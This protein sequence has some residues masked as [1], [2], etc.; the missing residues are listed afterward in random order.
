[1]K[2]SKLIKESS[3]YVNSYLF[4]FMVT[5][6]LSVLLCSFGNIKGTQA[7]F[8][9]VTGVIGS[10]YK[11]IYSSNWPDVSFG[12]DQ[13]VVSNLSSSSYLI[14]NNLFN[15]PD[16]YEFIDWNTLSDG[17]GISYKPDDFVNIESVL[18]LYAQ[19]NIIVDDDEN[20]DSVEG[21]ITTGDKDD[22]SNS[23]SD[24]D[25]MS[26]S[27]D[28]SSN[29]EGDE[30]DMS[31]SL[32]DSDKDNSTGSSD[33]NEENSGSI[34][35]N[36][37]GSGT[38]G[39]GTGSSGSSGGQ[40]SANNAGV[41]GGSSSSGNVS[42]SDNSN[43]SSNESVQQ[44]NSIDEE[45]FVVY[46][47]K[48]MNGNNEFAST[49]CEILKDNY[50]ELL[51]PKDNPIKDGYT[52]KGWSLSNLCSANDIIIEPVK[53]NSDNTYYACFEINVDTKNEDNGWIY[54]VI[55]VWV[56]ASVAIYFAIRKFKKNNRLEENG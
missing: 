39:S 43:T 11:V 5:I 54:L 18:Y 48:F 15:V 53:V 6:L 56:I 47:F 30:D 36:G 1:M 16:G 29:S 2:Y 38:T 42:S 22:S 3:R 24:E 19:W 41:A 20:N 37:T 12:A 31:G 40:N 14:R 26:G 7:S 33:N 32:D 23:E 13:T 45:I 35:N 10:S 25:D 21:D 4:S 34:S 28:D 17:S 46:K 50:C 51:L 27:L 52:F 55:S 44:E 9:G 49:S 8:G